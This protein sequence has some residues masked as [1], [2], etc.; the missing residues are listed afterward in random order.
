MKNILLL[1]IFSSLL[2]AQTFKTKKVGEIEVDFNSDIPI[3]TICRNN[4]QW[5]IIEDHYKT[6]I[7][8][9]QV[10]VDPKDA[11]KGTMPIICNF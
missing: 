3:K 6:G 5:V 7:A 8:L 2:S 4:L 1:A 11:S 9:D 10:L